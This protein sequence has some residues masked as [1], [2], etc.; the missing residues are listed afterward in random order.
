MTK[1]GQKADANHAAVGSDGTDMG[2]EVTDEG[3]KL[4]KE[5]IR[6]QEH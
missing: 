4:V 5:M 3:R 2:G 1:C 6:I